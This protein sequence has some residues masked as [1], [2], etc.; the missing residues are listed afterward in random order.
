MEAQE[1]RGKPWTER[2]IR[3]IVDAYAEMLELEAVGVPY[4]KAERNRAVRELLP[5]RSRGS[6][7]RK[8]Q[9]IS[10]CL[11]ALGIPWIRGYKPLPNAQEGLRQ[12]V[13]ERLWQVGGDGRRP[14]RCSE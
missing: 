7:E 3:V 8:H 2:E 10:A 1:R 6:I 4:S 5:A 9:N 11:D 13:R 12:T 14:G